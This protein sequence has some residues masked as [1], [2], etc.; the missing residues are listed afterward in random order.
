MPMSLGVAA[1]LTNAEFCLCQGEELPPEGKLVIVMCSDES[2]LGYRDTH[3]RWR[4]AVHHKVIYDVMA[5]CAL[6]AKG[7]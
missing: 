7:W 3:G 5:W 2:H 1:K 6:S 4:H